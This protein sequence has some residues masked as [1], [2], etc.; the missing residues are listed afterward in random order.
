MNGVR[1][2]VQE[3]LHRKKGERNEQFVS[4][5]DN[6]GI[7]Y[8]DWVITGSFY[9]AIHFL[10]YYFH[11][12]VPGYN[13]ETNDPPI[14]DSKGKR[15]T[16]HQHRKVLVKRYLRQLL[17]EYNYLNTLSREARYLDLDM[18]HVS[19]ADLAE[20]KKAVATKFRTLT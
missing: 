5:L 15:L 12:H 18:S 13:D 9:A 7:D 6:K 20:I 3:S 2:R 14:R 19:A 17:S 11:R 1:A 8:R 4:D 16:H 10:M